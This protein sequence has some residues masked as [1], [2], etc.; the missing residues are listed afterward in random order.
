[1]FAFVGVAAWKY[2]GCADPVMVLARLVVQGLPNEQ[3][4]QDRHG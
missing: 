3:K 2:G 4:K 1:V